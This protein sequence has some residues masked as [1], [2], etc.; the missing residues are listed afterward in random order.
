MDIHYLEGKRY[1]VHLACG[2]GQNLTFQFLADAEL[3]S[4]MDK[5]E[6]DD[7][8]AAQLSHHRAKANAPPHIPVCSDA[9]MQV[10]NDS[11]F[12]C[13]GRSFIIPQINSNMY[14]TKSD[15]T[16]KLA[17]GKNWI[18]ETLSNAML[19]PSE[20]NYT[21]QITHRVYGGRTH[22]YEVDSRDFF[23]YFS[24][25]YDR[26]FGIE[27]VD[28]DILAG[29]LILSD[30]NAGNIHI[31]FV[32]I[33]VLDLLNGGIMKIQLNTN[34]PQHN[35]ETLFGRTRE[36]SSDNQFIINIR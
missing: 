15:D 33:S 23:D 24:N 20:R 17:F 3:L 22:L 5:K 29:T 32:S 26:F 4:D 30:K 6:R 1:E 18:V 11:A 25:E 10:H 21:V 28:R 31:A 8:I 14:Y 13:M 7:R 2:Q 19:A 34:I 12:V 9:I 35:V 27:S 36:T 16:F